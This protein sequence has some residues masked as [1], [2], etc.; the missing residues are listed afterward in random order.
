MGLLKS[1]LNRV[2]NRD[3][4][5]SLPA[6]QSEEK[7]ETNGK[8]VEE[9]ETKPMQTEY[10]T[11]INYEES[12]DAHTEDK[13]K[14]IICQFAQALKEYDDWYSTLI[15][16]EEKGY[17]GAIDIIPN[18]ENEMGEKADL[19]ILNYRSAITNK[20]IK[21]YYRKHRR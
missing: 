11:E 12:Q 18:V 3:E 9:T 14:V 19:V 7:K 20:A 17:H 10:E 1:L 21:L 8:K 16:D 5:K 6:P 4:I 13:R 15:H 2:F